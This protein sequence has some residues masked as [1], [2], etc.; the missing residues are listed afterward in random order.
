MVAGWRPGL[1]RQGWLAGQVGAG[2]EG[3]GQG[4][5]GRGSFVREHGDLAGEGESV[6]G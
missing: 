1:D 6:V 5:A 2:V 4:L 3:G